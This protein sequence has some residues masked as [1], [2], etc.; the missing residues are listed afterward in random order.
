M[1][2]T[3]DEALN[4]RDELLDAIQQID[5]QLA[6]YREMYDVLAAPTERI[7]WRRQALEAKRHRC[8]ELRVVK[9][10]IKEN[11]RASE[12]DVLREV[13]YYFDT[14]RMDNEAIAIVARIEAMLPKHYIASRDRE[15]AS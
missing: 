6:D 8:A 11:H 2:K 15:K 9:R 7:A 12:W 14:H 13:W 5:V 1:F 3:L 10:W 4:R